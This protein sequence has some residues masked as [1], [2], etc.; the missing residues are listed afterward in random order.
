MT[1]TKVKTVFFSVV[2]NGLF[3]LSYF[4]FF[5][6]NFAQNFAQSYKNNTIYTNLHLNAIV[7]IQNSRYISV[8][9]KILKIKFHLENKVYQKINKR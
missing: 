8:K 3:F 7:H 9:L 5:L 4:L 6:K 2:L 1:I